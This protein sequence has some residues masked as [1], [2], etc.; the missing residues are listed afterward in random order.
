M[1]KFIKAD[2]DEYEEE[3]DMESDY[4]TIERATVAVDTLSAWVDSIKAGIEEFEQE[5]SPWGGPTS[6]W[7]MFA[8][9]DDAEDFSDQMYEL[10]NEFEKL[11]GK[12][13]DL[14]NVYIRPDNI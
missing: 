14:L 9:P 12:L 4:E 8:G 5:Y 10:T 2:Y 3:Y 6:D 7:E 11:A 1:K 13:G